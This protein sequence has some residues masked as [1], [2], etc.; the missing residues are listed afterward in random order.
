MHLYMED[1]LH[2]LYDLLT[3]DVKSRLG[4]H[5]LMRANQHVFIATAMTSTDFIS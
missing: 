3:A 2:A 4:L 5:F 1:D